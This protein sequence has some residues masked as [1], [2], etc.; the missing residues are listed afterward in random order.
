MYA[1]KTDPVENNIGTRV[2]RREKG[3]DRLPPYPD[4]PGGD[5]RGP[6]GE[7]QWPAGGGYTAWTERATKTPA[8]VKG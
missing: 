7:A 4:E 3:S 8:W 5:P 2:E 6:G 1:K